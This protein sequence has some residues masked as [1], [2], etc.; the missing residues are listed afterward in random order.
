M[1]E[2]SEKA[3]EEIK[4]VLA[5]REEKAAVRVLLSEGG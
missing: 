2:V 4:K 1:F 3:Q 5:E